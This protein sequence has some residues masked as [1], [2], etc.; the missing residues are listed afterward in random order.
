MEAMQL[1]ENAKLTVETIIE[2]GGNLLIYN[3]L[4]FSAL[5]EWNQAVWLLFTEIGIASNIDVK[6]PIGS[7]YKN[8]Q[9]VS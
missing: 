6:A 2:N 9:I 3:K 4:Q 8:Y 1:L 5:E 7:T